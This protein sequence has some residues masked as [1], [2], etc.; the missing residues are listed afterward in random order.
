MRHQ[1]QFDVNFCYP[2]AGILSEIYGR[3]FGFLVDHFPY[4]LLV[5][6]F[7]FFL[8]FVKFKLFF[9]FIICLFSLKNYDKKH[10]IFSKVEK[11]PNI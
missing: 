9:L 8:I 7:I 2:K 1:N 6:L 11:I 10:K 5:F 3:R 4:I